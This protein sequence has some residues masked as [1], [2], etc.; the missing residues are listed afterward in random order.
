M[1]SMFASQRSHRAPLLLVSLFVLALGLNACDQGA[2]EGNLALST[3]LNGSTHDVEGFLFE[4]VCDDGFTLTEYVSLENE[5][6]PSWLDSS[7]GPGHPFADLLALVPPGDCVVT[8]TP[9]QDPDTPSEDCAPVTAAFTVFPGQTT[10]LTLMAECRS[11]PD[12]AVDIAVGL[13]DAPQILDLV[14]KPGKFICVGEKLPIYLDA[15]DPNGDAI[16]IEWEVTGWPEAPAP[17]DF[18]LTPATG[19]D[20]T[21]VGNTVGPYEITVT[22]TDSYG[23]TTS[24]SFPVHALPCEVCCETAIGWTIVPTDEC[25]PN[26]QV[27]FELCEDSCACPDGYDPTPDG[28][29]CVST[30]TVAATGSASLEV[31]A[32]R[33]HFNYGAYGANYPGGTIVPNTFW[34]PGVLSDSDPNNDGRL[35]TIGVWACDNVP[36]DFLDNP[37][38]EWIGFSVCLD[39]AEAG[40]YMVGMA[41]DNQARFYINNDPI[42]TLSLLGNSVNNFRYW[43]LEVVTLAAGPNIITLEGRNNGQIA[44]YGAEIS[45]PFTA[46]SLSSDAA[47]IAADYEGN[48]IWST[49]DMI[50][51]SFTI[52][53]TSGYQCPD[54]YVLSTCGDPECILI[55]YVDCQ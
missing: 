42:P 51:Q 17:G 2:D 19:A 52:G 54:G 10:E 48:L 29:Q 40:D 46:G 55:D 45:G 49:G 21:F 38:G 44:A 39:I 8:A 32:G 16:L 20:V 9:M 25:P 30:D 33:D 4:I 7:A 34:G 23:S 15:I 26:Q 43:W 13:N 37:V 36:G 47:M 31:C 24:L 6:L 1:E 27:A 12:G 14:L 50:G 41:A 5:P 3:A 18:S 28:S 53:E 35:N 11:E 22:V